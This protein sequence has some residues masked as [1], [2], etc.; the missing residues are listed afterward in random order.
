MIIS[1]RTASNQCTKS[2]YININICHRSA[3]QSTS[4]HLDQID[5]SILCT[6]VFKKKRST[7][8]DRR[9]NS[10]GRFVSHTEAAI[11]NFPNDSEDLEY[12][13]SG[14]AGVGVFSK[15]EIRKGRVVEYEGEFVGVKEIESKKHYYK[16][17]SHI[18]S[19][20]FYTLKYNA[21]FIDATEKG[22]IARFINHSCVPNCT[23][24]QRGKKI[25]IY[26]KEVIPPNTELTLN[27]SLTGQKKERCNCGERNCKGWI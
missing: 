3:L 24:H 15:R 11:M 19:T 17:A 27:Y 16:H 13:P 18:T 26:A 23:A 21:G 7:G 12:R 5:L 4:V 10:R 9:R 1:L 22:N 8:L 20:Y 25:Y 2:N 14:I 6:M